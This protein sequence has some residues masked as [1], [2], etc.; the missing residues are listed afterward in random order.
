MLNRNLR[1]LLAPWGVDVPDLFLRE[2]TS[3]S[4]LVSAGDLFMAV[5]GHTID[6]RFYIPQAIHQGVAAVIAES[7]EKLGVQTII[8][9]DGIPIV[10]LHEIKKHLSRIAGIFYNHPAAHLYL[11]AVTGT[12]G[13]TTVTQLIAQWGVLLGETSA[14]MGT[15]GNGVLG[16]VIP[17]ANT[18][19]SAVD[20]QFLLNS[21]LSKGATLTAMEVSSHA[22]AQNRVAALPF[23]ASVFT[24]LS[25]DHLDY[26][27]N[28]H[29]YAQIKWLLF[30]T[31]DSGEM[32]IN[33]DD[34]LG[35]D[36]LSKLPNAIAVTMKK[37]LQ[38]NFSRRLVSLT[39]VE[40]QEG[41]ANIF[42]N[43]SWGKGVLKS[44]LIGSFNVSNLLLAVATMLALGYPLNEL[45]KTSIQL[46]PI[47]GRME[48]FNAPGKPTVFVDYAHTPDALHEA[49]QAARLQCKG[50]LWCIFG[51]GGNRD[52][53]KRSIMGSVAEQYA[54]RVVITDDNP[55]K[56]N[57]KGIMDDILN[58]IVD[59]KHVQKISDRSEAV[60]YAIKQAKQADVILIAG[61]GHENYQ[62][63]GNSELYC[64]DRDTVSLLLRGAEC[65][66]FP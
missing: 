25:R 30:S 18:T 16:K 66:L 38:K 19:C 35:Y 7:Y 32:I 34:K 63:I 53:G 60:T 50:Q 8:Q 44:R 4:R 28:M 5:V 1:A 56:E 58:G 31:H 21:F 43:S 48:S 24:N 14:V 13:K 23:A 40:H 15:I 62:L 57:P 51:C 12:N 59:T 39:A 9:R 46:R 52:Q 47:F 6:A 27:G 64:S 65:S 45:C 11:I 55:R 26:H 36:W 54:D 42:F 3:D 17:S 49:L 2:M 61:K 10:Y 22:L 33:A 41:F 37:H 29:Q 20:V